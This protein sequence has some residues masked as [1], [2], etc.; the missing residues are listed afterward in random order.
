MS[1]FI[2]LCKLDKNIK[3]WVIN[4]LKV[5]GRISDC[6]MIW[7]KGLQPWYIP[8]LPSSEITKEQKI[9]VHPF[10]TSRAAGLPWGERLWLTI[11]LFYV[12]QAWAGSAVVVWVPSSYWPTQ[13]GYLRR[14]P[15]PDKVASVVPTVQQGELLW[16]SQQQRWECEKGNLYVNGCYN[17]DCSVGPNLFSFFHFMSFVL[18]VDLFEKQHVLLFYCKRKMFS[19]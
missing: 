19:I 16:P 1:L 12:L 5:L 9:S 3:S 15:D 7:S 11:L 10:S 6:Q 14:S 2:G 13:G 8:P 4:I 17:L 18:V